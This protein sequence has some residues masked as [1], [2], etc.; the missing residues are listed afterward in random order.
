MSVNQ[1]GLVD[2][3]GQIDADLVHSAAIALNLQGSSPVLAG[4]GDRHVPS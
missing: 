4:L 3:T 1:V 2:M